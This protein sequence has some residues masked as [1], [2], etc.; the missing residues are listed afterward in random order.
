MKAWTKPKEVDYFY[1][2]GDTPEFREWLSVVRVKRSMYDGMDMLSRNCGRD[3]MFMPQPNIYIVVEEKTMYNLDKKQFEDNYLLVNPRSIG[4]E[5]QPYQG[6]FYDNNPSN[7][8]KALRE[9]AYPQELKDFMD[10]KMQ[11][12]VD[13]VNAEILENAMETWG[14]DIHRDRK[15]S[16]E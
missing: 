7:V 16:N 12:I 11:E 4:V 2:E 3:H 9:K 6:A 5:R 14:I 8:T 10:K 13:H 1:Y 15:E